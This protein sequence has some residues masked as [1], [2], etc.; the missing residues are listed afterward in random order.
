MASLGK[1]IFVLIVCVFISGCTVHFKATDLELDAERQRVNT[2]DTYKLE[3]VDIF[4]R[5]S[6]DSKESSRTDFKKSVR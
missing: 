5:K 6:G 3:K 4:V 2:N 1:T